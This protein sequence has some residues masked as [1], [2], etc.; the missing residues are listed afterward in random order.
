MDILDLDRKS[1]E[2]GDRKFLF[3]KFI[4]PKSMLVWE[5]N[6]LSNG[7]DKRDNKHQTCKGIDV[8]DCDVETLKALEV[9]DSLPLDVQTTIGIKKVEEVQQVHNLMAKARA[10]RKQRYENIPLTI[11][12][13]E[14]GNVVEVVKCAV[15]KAVE[16]KRI[17]KP[18]YL[19]TDYIKEFKCR[20][21]SPVIRMGRQP[22]PLFANLPPVMTCSC[23]KKVSTNPHYLKV[24]AE[25][26]GVTIQSLIENFK[27]QG[28]CPSKGKKKSTKVKVISNEP[29]K[30]RGRPRNVLTCTE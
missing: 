14:C 4:P 6:E 22:N 2:L 26:M 7:E 27:C 29:K 19:L 15:A 30:K 9:W 24:K 16:K 5:K 21:C 25:K 20:K 23:G 1:F 11:T 17:L 18:D 3:V 8:H 12:C 28:C 13:T 10:S